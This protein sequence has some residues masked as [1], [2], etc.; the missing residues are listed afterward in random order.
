MVVIWIARLFW[1]RLYY[2]SQYW[3]NVFNKAYWD[4]LKQS[5]YGIFYMSRFSVILC[6]LVKGIILIFYMRNG[7]FQYRRLNSFL[8]TILVTLYGERRIIVIGSYLSIIKILIRLY[9]GSKI[10]GTW[11]TDGLSLS[12]LLV[13]LSW[14]GGCLQ[15]NLYAG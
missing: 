11:W 15:Q 3:L 9:V 6:Y 2:K 8:M 12:Q 7:H 14:G 10:N 13:I 5:R 4:E 1:Q